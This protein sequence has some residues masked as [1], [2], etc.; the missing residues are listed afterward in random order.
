[1]RKMFVVVGLVALALPVA[2][3]A[4]DGGYQMKQ[5]MYADAAAGHP[6]SLIQSCRAN[7]P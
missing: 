5:A 2:A 6:H 7:G 4:D 1:M 3:F